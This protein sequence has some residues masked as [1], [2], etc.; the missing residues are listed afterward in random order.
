MARQPQCLDAMPKKAFLGGKPP[1]VSSD[2]SYLHSNID[3]SRPDG[4]WQNPEPTNFT[5]V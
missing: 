5:E 1:R 2:N 3:G 4:A